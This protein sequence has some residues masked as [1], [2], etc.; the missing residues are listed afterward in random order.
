MPVH[1]TFDNTT[2]ADIEGYRISACFQP[3]L[4]FNGAFHIYIHEAISADQDFAPIDMSVPDAAIGPKSGTL[5]FQ[6]GAN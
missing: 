2:L 4:G 3:A 6:D 5:T 1:A